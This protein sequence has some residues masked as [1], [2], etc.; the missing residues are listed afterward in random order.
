MRPA[1]SL[2]EDETG[3]GKRNEEQKKKEKRAK[4]MK[5]LK[6]ENEQLTASSLIRDRGQR[7][8]RSKAKL[9]QS[10]SGCEKKDQEE[11][12]HVERSL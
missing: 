4:A 1:H 9:L 6:N 3:H 11:S 10:L 2:L 12:V 5:N 8:R 7:A